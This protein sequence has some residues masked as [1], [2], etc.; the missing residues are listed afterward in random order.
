MKNKTLLLIANGDLRLSA[1]QNCWAEQE[2]METELCKLAKSMGYTILRAHAYDPAAKHGFI[3]SQRQGMDIFS[4]IDRSLPIIVAEA[5]WQY[6]HHILAGLISHEGPIL[7]LANWSG[8]WPGLVGML[9]LN[10]SL[11]KANVAYSSLW[12]ED[13]FGDAHFKSQFSRW[14]E[15]G[16]IEQDASHVSPYTNNEYLSDSVLASIDSI[17]E[18]IDREKCIMGV[19]DEFCMGMY[20]AAIPDELLFNIGVYKERLSQSALFAEMQTVS[21]TEAVEVFNWIKERGFNFHFGSDSDSELTESQVLDQCKMYIASCRIGERF[22]CDAI[23][24]Q[25]QQ[26][27]KDVCPASD[28][29]EGML[30]SSD[31]PPVKNSEGKTIFEGE[32]FT[33]FNEVDEC[34][35]LDAIITK[36]LHKALGQPLEITLHDLRWG[37]FDASGTTD[38]YVWVFLISGAAPIEHHISGWKGSH[39]YRQPAMYFPKGGSTLHGVAKP[40]TII[41]SR[42]YIEDSRLKMDIGLAEVIELPEAET[43]RRLNETT[44]EWPIMNAV[45]KGISRDQMMARHKANHLNVVY[46]NDA[47]SAQECLWAKAELAKRLNIEVFICGNESF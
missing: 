22:G 45:L 12:S 11:T 30:N 41:W 8:K 5:V 24:I 26:G 46:A 36:R 27:L 23:G 10:G 34:A 28:L 1:N 9:N 17:V 33:H 44:P 19:F 21:E 2:A 4:K 6:S 15:Y 35:G 40:G 13:F 39:G 43:R 47:V 16:S 37:D 7:T 14:L 32:P 20:N 38:E 31:R 3:S 25:Y 29:V 18:T 42:I